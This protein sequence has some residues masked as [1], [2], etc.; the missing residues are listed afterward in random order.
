MANHPSALKR[1]RQ[2]RRRTLRNRANASRVRTAMKKLR[3][4]IAAKDASAARDLLAPTLSQIDKSIQKGVLH[5]NA[6][7]RYKSHL[8]LACNALKK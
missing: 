7:A 6:A 5:R 3:A 8:T 4:A 1:V 2:T